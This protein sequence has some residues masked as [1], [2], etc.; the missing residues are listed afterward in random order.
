MAEFSFDLKLGT[1]ECR[2]QFGNQFLSG[3]AS[4]AEAPLEV[5]VESPGMSGV[6][7]MLVETCGVVMTEGF[8]VIALREDDD[9][10]RGRVIGFVA[11][12][13]NVGGDA[14]QEELN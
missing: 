6:M 4:T 8:K 14:T 13:T 5:A 9:V 10:L 12:M 3:I 1:E 2:S 7:D 11:S